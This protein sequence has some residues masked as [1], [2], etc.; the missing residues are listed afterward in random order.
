M[1][2]LA[3]DALGRCYADA[4]QFGGS[5]MQGLQRK[6]DAGRN[7]AA[8]IIALGIDDIERR[9]R[10]EIDDQQRRFIRYRAADGVDDA[11]GADFLGPVEQ[12]F[13]ADIDMRGA[14]HHRRAAEML[15][16]QLGQVEIGFRHHAADNRGLNRGGIEFFVLHQ[17]MQKHRIFV[18][19]M[20]RV[21]RTPPRRPA[22]FRR[23]TGRKRCWYY[24]HR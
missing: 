19:R 1:G 21:G 10:A 11:V 22:W 2:V 24:R 14:D 12:D 20:P 17:R 13:D 9:R 18:G 3:D 7:R 8:A 5:H 15:A 16:A 23:R 6:I 4:R